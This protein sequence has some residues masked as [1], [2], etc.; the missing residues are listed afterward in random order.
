LNDSKKC[1]D[2]PLRPA[3][4]STCSHLLRHRRS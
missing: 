3:P 4:G 2:A 1:A